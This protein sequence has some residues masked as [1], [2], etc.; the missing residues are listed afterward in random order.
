MDAKVIYKQS[1]PIIKRFTLQ[2]RDDI[3]LRRASSEVVHELPETLQKRV[4]VLMLVL[5][6][7][8]VVVAVAVVV[9]VVMVAVVV[10]GPL[11]LVAVPEREPRLHVADL[12]PPGG[13]LA[14]SVAEH[15]IG[16]K[17][18][19]AGQDHVV[20][21]GDEIAIGVGPSRAPRLEVLAAAAA[22][23]ERQREGTPREVAVDGTETDHR[24][25]NGVVF[26]D[27]LELDWYFRHRL[28]IGLRFLGG[29]GDTI[30]GCGDFTVVSFRQNLCADGVV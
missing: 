26:F 19:S 23:A 27:C 28:P 7:V 12:D 6:M 22:V 14:H 1:S 11:D 15:R 29:K 10:V 4:L 30:G 2:N 16:V 25:R 9:V 13:D 21:E 3:P 8:V 5:M 20:A 17:P 24:Q 18:I